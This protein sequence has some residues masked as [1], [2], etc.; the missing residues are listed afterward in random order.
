MQNFPFPSWRSWLKSLA[1]IGYIIP[2]AIASR[3][4]GEMTYNLFH[5]RPDLSLKFWIWLVF[6]L[7][8]PQIIAIAFI[9]HI[10]FGR[11]RIQP[12]RWVPRKESWGYGVVAW[13]IGSIAAVVA[14]LPYLISIAAGDSLG[15]LVRSLDESDPRNG[16]ALILFLAAG[17]YLYHGKASIGD[18]LSLTQSLKSQPRH[19]D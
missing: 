2:G 1:L 10:L 3:M 11:E 19:R 13:L 8:V 17:A 15:E 9:H 7:S 16:F 18:H 4:L 14:M 6:T 12:P 5:V